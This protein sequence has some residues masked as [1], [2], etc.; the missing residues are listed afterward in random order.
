M[1]SGWTCLLGCYS[2]S[3]GF[4]PERLRNCPPLNP[5]FVLRIEGAECNPIEDEMFRPAVTSFLETNLKLKGMECYKLEGLIFCVDMRNWGW[6]MLSWG[7]P[8]SW[9]RNS[10][11][12][13]FVPFDC[14]GIPL[15]GSLQGL[16]SRSV[17]KV[18]QPGSLGLV[19]V[20][21]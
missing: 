10:K 21:L 12:S 9:D 17:E 2:F 16:I 11:S 1:N 14:V 13:W 4:N 19:C 3:I 7:S 6:R 8:L 15:G 20:N 18:V 5:R